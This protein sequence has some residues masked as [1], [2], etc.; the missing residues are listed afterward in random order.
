MKTWRLALIAPGGGRVSL[1]RALV[2]FLACCIAPA[3]AIA[4]FRLL[5]PL[6]YG[7]WA[8]ALLALNYAWAMVDPDLKLLQDRIAGTR[9]VKRFAV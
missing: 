1:A 9:L 4:G 5:Q 7:R 2:R 6:G 8:A 3:L